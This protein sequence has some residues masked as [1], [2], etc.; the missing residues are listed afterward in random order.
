MKLLFLLVLPLV[1]ASEDIWLPYTD[2]PGYPRLNED[3]MK[4]R[5]SDV[6]NFIS[7]TKSH[8]DSYLSGN[9]TE[10]EFGILHNSLINHYNDEVEHDQVIK[11]MVLMPIY[12][13]YEVRYSCSIRSINIDDNVVSSCDSTIFFYNM[14]ISYSKLCPALKYFYDVN[15]PYISLYNMSACVLCGYSYKISTPNDGPIKYAV[16]NMDNLTSMV[17]NDTLTYMYMSIT[18]V[19]LIL[20]F[21]IN[22]HLRISSTGI[23]AHHIISNLKID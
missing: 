12:S 20:L 13:Q 19:L 11:D 23:S 14:G 17:H 22:C 2:I 1:W 3:R 18:V 10:K 9:T 16:P 8:I 15:N 6:K 21:C 5:E 4:L 7:T